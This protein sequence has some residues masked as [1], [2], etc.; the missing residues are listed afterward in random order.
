[1]RLFGEDLDALHQDG[2]TVESCQ[3]EKLEAPSLY[4]YIILYIFEKN[5]PQMPSDSAF[6]TPISLSMFHDP[7][8]H[9]DHVLRRIQMKIHAIWT[10]FNR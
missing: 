3:G 6:I 4:T 1:V 9:Y 5:V 10:S 8:A 7:T 2:S